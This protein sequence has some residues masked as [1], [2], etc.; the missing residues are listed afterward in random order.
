MPDS[1]RMRKSPAKLALPLLQWYDKV[2]QNRDM[3]WRQTRDPYAI[4]LSET[5]LQQTQVETVK[6]YYARFL[7]YFPTIRALAAAP[8]EEVLTLWAGLGY[9]RRARHLHAAAQQVIARHKGALPSDVDALMSLPGIGRYTAGAVGSIAFGLA[10]P[11]VDGNVM[12]VLS[13]LT[14]YDKD[15]ANPRNAEFFWTLAAE[16]LRG[17]ASSDAAPRYGDVNQSLMELGATVCTPASPKCAECPVSSFCR[18]L[19]EGRAAELPVK[20]KRGKTPGIRGTA[21]V[22]LNPTGDKVLLMKRPR[23]GIWEEMWEFPVLTNKIDR[24]KAVENE[25][26]LAVTAVRP[27]GTVT[28]QLT[29]RRIE[30]QVVACKA[31]ATGQMKLPSCATGGTYSEAR[32]VVWPLQK[33]G[34]PISTLVRKIAK[35]V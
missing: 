7:E 17:T 8:L 33:T 24:G 20:L 34:L 28:H 3:P 14:G 35:V 30:Y 12:R 1:Y 13:R 15:I 18:A 23:G 29:H 21:L 4:W 27:C 19:A 16:I 6:P 25:I 10:A 31:S 2:H 5:M 32:W 26:G 22:I 9:Y 11:V